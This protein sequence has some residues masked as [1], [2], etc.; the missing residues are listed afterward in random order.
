[1]KSCVMRGCDEPRECGKFCVKH[2]LEGA[3]HSPGSIRRY[4]NPK[5]KKFATTMRKDQTNHER[6]LWEQLRCKR[7]GG[8]VFRR[9]AVIR[10]YIVDFYCPSRSLAIEVDGPTHDAHRDAIR[11]R[12]IKKL[13]IDVLRFSNW[14]VRNQLPQ[15]LDRIAHKCGVVSFPR[16]HSTHHHNK[17]DLK[18]KERPVVERIYRGGNVEKEKLINALSKLPDSSCRKIVED[19]V[20]N[21]ASR[22]SCTRQ[23]FANMEVAEDTARAFFSLGIHATP[24]R[25]EICGLLHLLELR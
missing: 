6:L 25:C 21:G 12:N 17:G 22:G 11:D 9:Q 23:V 1:M 10:G 4:I 18:V 14:A 19:R 13:S 15:V 20:N 16:I 2:R 5:T 3:R 24:E 8:L 7:L